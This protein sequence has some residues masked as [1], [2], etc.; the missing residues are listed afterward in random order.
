MLKRLNNTKTTRQHSLHDSVVM[1]IVQ[2]N[3][4]DKSY[5]KM[6]F[7]CIL[8]GS[9]NKNNHKLENHISR[10]IKMFYVRLLN[11]LMSDQDIHLY[12]Y[13]ELRS[14]YKYHIDLYIALYQHKTKNEE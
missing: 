10:L 12:K 2:M 11:N 6:K 4:Y 13:S 1:I 9:K 8:F 14:F 7:L 3:F 5:D